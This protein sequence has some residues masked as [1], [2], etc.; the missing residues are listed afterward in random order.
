MC[1]HEEIY[2]DENGNSICLGCGKRLR[3]DNYEQDT[4]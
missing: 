4:T 2:F 3:S 1:V